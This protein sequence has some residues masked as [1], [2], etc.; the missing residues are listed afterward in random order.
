[1]K[2][3]NVCNLIDDLLPIYIEDLANDDTK[4]FIEEHIKTCEK[5]KQKVED[6]RV[7]L[8]SSEFETNDIDKSEIDGLKKVRNRNRLKIL[9]AVIIVSILF[10]IGIWL[11]R[12][13]NIY[14]DENGKVVVE[15][16]KMNIYTMDC[17]ICKIVTRMQA[18]D[19]IDGYL[20]T[21]IFLSFDSNINCV[22]MRCVE[23]GYTE[24]GIQ[25]VYNNMKKSEGLNY[26][27]NI[28]ILE[29]KLKYNCN[30]FNLKKKNEVISEIINAYGEILEI[31][32]W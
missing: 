15:N 13:Y 2:E 8:G 1:M 26:K 14:L 9:I 20:Y 25:Y 5:C 18:E 22:N 30:V 28:K 27:S 32:E 21:T 19:T 16:I 23:E 17:S 24:K 12:H 10:G 6:M 4:M 3:I 11:N 29:D 7:N 31:S